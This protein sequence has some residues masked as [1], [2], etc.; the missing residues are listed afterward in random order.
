MKTQSLA[1]PVG[2]MN[3]MKWLTFFWNWL[4]DNIFISTLLFLLAQRKLASI[5][6]NIEN[7]SIFIYVL[8]SDT[9]IQYAQS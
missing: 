5:S 2:G 3:I 4:T 6:E 9:E 7:T 8:T 1:L